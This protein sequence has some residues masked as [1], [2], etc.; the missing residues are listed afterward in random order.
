MSSVLRRS[1]FAP[2][3]FL[4]LSALCL[5][6][7][8]LSVPIASK[9]LYRGQAGD[10][11]HY[12][13][14]E[15]CDAHA[16]NWNATGA[17]GTSCQSVVVDPTQNGY[18]YNPWGE[19]Y[20]LLNGSSTITFAPGRQYFC[21]GTW[22]GYEAICPTPIFVGPCDTCVSNPI[23]PGT[24]N[25]IQAELDFIGAGPF[26]LTYRRTYNRSVPV[27][28]ITQ[29][30]SPVNDLA[31]LIN[32]QWTTFRAVF[33]GWFSQTSTGIGSWPGN[34]QRRIVFGAIPTVATVTVVRPD[35][36]IYYFS[37]IAGVWTANVNITDT[38]TESV[39][40][41]GATTG[42]RYLTSADESEL[43]SATGK[44]LSIT[45]RAGLIHTLTYS[46]G[47]TGPNGGFILDLAGNPTTAVL[48]AGLLI[49]VSDPSSRTLT[50]G[51]DVNGRLVKMTNPTGG[52]YL[53]GYDSNNNMTSVT[54][55]DGRIRQYVYN[56][57]AWT[58]STNQ[59]SALTGVIDE[60]N[61]R[62]GTYGYDS[63]GRAVSSE[64]ATAGID[65]STLTY[66][67]DGTVTVADPRLTARTYGFTNILG[68]VQTTGITQPCAPS[69]CTGTV[70]SSATY[71]VNGNASSRLD[72][73]QNRTCYAYD[74]SRNL[75][76]KRVEGLASSSVCSTVLVTPPAPTTANPV[77]TI[78]TAWHP[79]WR[80]AVKVAEPKRIT[81]YVYNGQPDPSNGN[82]A[83]TCAPTTA[84]VNGL[85][86]AVL[87]KK[88]L[89]STSDAT[90]SLGF[91]ATLTGT[92]RIWQTTYNNNGMALTEDGPRTDV[93]DV[94]TY[95]YYLDNDTDLGKRG[96]VSSIT[97]ALGH[98]TNI[99]AYNPHGQPLNITD[100]NGLVTT[101]EYDARQRLV[102]KSSGPAVL[103][104]CSTVTPV[105]A[106]HERTLYQYDGVGQLTQ[107]TSPDTSYIHYT[108]DPAHRLTDLT[109]NQN[110]L[111][112]YTLDN[113]G[114]RTQEDVK[115]PA[116]NIKRT[117][118]RL[119]DALNRLWK[120]IGGVNPATEITQYGYDNQ[121]NLKTVT[122]ARGQVTTQSFDALNRLI[123]VLQP[124]PVAGQTQPLTQ[125]SYSGLDQLTSV[126][127]ARNLA[128]Q[129]TRDGLD[130]LAQQVSPDTG[131]TINTQDAAGNVVTSQDAKT[132]LTTTTY[133]ALNRVSLVTYQDS[134]NVQ[135]GYD[136]GTNAKG[137]LSSITDRSSTQA[138]TSQ[139]SYTYEAHG[140]LA[141]ETRVIGA[142]TFLTQYGY[143]PLGRLTSITYPSGL[144]LTYTLDALGRISG[145]TSTRNGQAASLLSNVTYEP[146]GEV[147]SFT[148]GNGQTST[149]SRD[150]DGRINGYT[151]ANQSHS[152]TWDDASRITGLTATANNTL[153]QT[154]GYDNL[155]RL[156]GVATPITA[157]AYDYD[158]VGNRVSQ[159]TGVNTTTTAMAA[160]SNRIASI[161][162][163]TGSVRSVISDAN[164]AITADGL[165]T[166]T[167]DARGR[168]I[169]ATG[170][171]G[172]AS[173]TLN[174]LG[175]RIKKTVGTTTT[176]YHYD[177]AGHLI[178]EA[179]A[180]GVTQVEYLW[181]ADQPVALFK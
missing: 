90:G 89:Q 104:N 96:N 41:T 171:A 28:T 124:V 51:Y 141:S 134:S 9:Y 68:H 105:P 6:T 63:Q 43:Y 162:P 64:H 45:N 14:Q 137:R 107:V 125:Y 167:Y 10:L 121:G 174:A 108:Y 181:L 44:L 156:T 178:A 75:E 143:D 47:T 18:P 149:R 117:H 35:G 53:Y 129:T 112:H 122:D 34:Y 135:Y 169:A 79:N 101:L 2:L 106:G 57:A 163:A 22:V 100:P 128:T 92:P 147:A 164:G 175:Q 74:L 73:N 87:C 177:T 19:K 113:M 159:T 80:L 180:A 15:V 65:K 115:D 62:L 39:D 54:Y 172:S 97:N 116:G 17:P 94:T 123:Q 20:T 30:S 25:K 132:Q 58:A 155:D 131:T 88:I 160:T 126:T 23:Y 139:I 83:L 5:S 3:L 166:F 84:L 60:N 130:N 109:D 81:T 91:S 8:A 86:I 148:F 72:F 59:P 50:F 82:A 127:D 76:T 78:S 154:Y 31:I 40:G 173:F 133:D 151:L 12:S 138:I 16:A 99:T 37:E 150:K 111:I 48:S 145:I 119:Y 179:N 161:T 32:T 7:D 103:A 67:T 24:G 4:A 168:Q 114:N 27:A 70:S 38:L 118:A 26:P 13:V 98:V 49:R 176:L 71:D 61:V 11:F 33:N 136:Q 157:Y 152:I 69:G 66:N 77:R 165:H 120:D 144:L 153:T 142:A 46:D 1:R 95:A 56:E 42:W 36:A 110:N 21:D 158:L 52:N 93:V 102:C 170:S 55:P 146:F 29:A 85:P 140:R